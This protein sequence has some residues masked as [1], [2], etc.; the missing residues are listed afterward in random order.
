MFLP[1]GDFLKPTTNYKLITLVS[2]KLA[3]PTPYFKVKNPLSID[4]LELTTVCKHQPHQWG[5]PRKIL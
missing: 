5:F 2:I 1:V 4:S 3:N